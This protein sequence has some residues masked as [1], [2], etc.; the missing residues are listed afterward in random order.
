MGNAS[1]R[2][3]Q[4]STLQ[5]AS[6]KVE[7]RPADSQKRPKGKGSPRVSK[8]KSAAEFKADYV[9]KGKTAKSNKV[10]DVVSRDGSQITYC[11]RRVNV[12]SMPQKSLPQLTK[13]VQALGNLEHPHICKFIECYQE[14][15]DVLLIYEKADPITIF[16]F[17]RTKGSLTEE[18]AAEYSR[19]VAMALSVAHNANMY[20][21]RLTP[22]KLLC[23]YRDNFDEEDAS[24][25]VKICDF[26]Q[27]FIVS[28]DPLEVAN[29]QL[30][31][32][33][34]D[35][36]FYCSS[37]EL[38]D[39]DLKQDVPDGEY[40]TGTAMARNDIWAFGAIVY[41]MLTGSLPFPKETTKTKEDLLKKIPNMAVD[42][43]KMS[44]LS[45][46]AQDA[47]EA[48]LKVNPGLRISAKA[49][50][51]HP[52]IK[53]AK[54]TFPKKRMVYLLHNLRL[55]CN[56]CE[57]RRFILRVMAEQLPPDSKQTTSIEDAFR[58]LDSNSDGLLSLDE[59][60]KGL[61]RYLDITESD[62]Q[63][64]FKSID[65]DG[66]GA[67]NVKEFIAATMDERLA[68]SVPTLWQVFSAFDQDESGH[69]SLG[70]IETVVKDIE[71]PQLG[72]DK[73]EE[74]CADIRSEL[75]AV[76]GSGANAGM[77]FDH[78]VYIMLNDQPSLSEA[79]KKNLFRI[80]WNRCAVDCYDVRHHAYEG[81]KVKA[82]APGGPQSVSGPAVSPRSPYRKR[83][84]QRAVD[85]AKN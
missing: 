6:Q 40:P 48:M 8:L 76:I 44:N 17:V 77:D 79:L 70:E 83:T 47:V 27:A 11:C 36:L 31:S 46:H 39:G 30:N 64:M 55:N 10:I 61:R 9:E 65:R 50:L 84:V 41:H 19:Q 13:H 3:C 38:S 68:M 69:I 24:A 72:K 52:W 25:Q 82:D 58:C 21:G 2:C 49:L 4:V 45:K 28:P 71:G 14:P 56:R 54:T 78:F 26:G 66:S 7:A 23:A 15:K 62:L 53:V 16:E 34:F 74:L 63:T 80:S 57:F 59:V 22:A 42:F 51:N 35:E 20:H 75:K 33:T 5:K 81:W 67:L 29:A 60:V 85:V 73:V 37:P 32:K 12:S 18:E 43:S 1:A